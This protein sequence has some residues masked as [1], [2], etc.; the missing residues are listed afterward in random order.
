MPGSGRCPP[1]QQQTLARLFDH[2]VGE[3]EQLIRHIQAERFGSLEVDDHFEFDWRLHRKVSW[4]LALEDT[5]DV[6]GRLPVPIDLIRPV[7]DQAA[8][9]D[10]GT[11]EV[12][13]GQFVSGRQCN[14][15]VT[16]ALC[17]R[18]GRD[19]QAAIRRARECRDIPLHLA[20]VAHIDW[21]HLHPERRRDGLDCAELANSG[22][23]GGIPNH[24][25]PRH[26][27]R[28]LLEQ[29]QPFPAA[30]ALAF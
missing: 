15:Q 30:T 6:A 26:T 1:H 29:L 23:Y 12:D 14:D 13:R 17:H 7:R 24:C 5:I 2:L 8:G 27:W 20:G 4:L 16:T 9:S 3:R 10:E 25:R 19:D 28:D 11:I 21:V 22:G 18:A